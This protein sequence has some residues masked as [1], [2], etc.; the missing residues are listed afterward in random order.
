MGCLFCDIAS[1]TIPAEIIYED[2]ASIVFKD[3]SPKAPTHVLVIPKSHLA[4]L[5]ATSEEHIQ[6]LGHLQRVCA[7]VAELLELNKSGYRVVTNIGND[8]GQTVE[9]LHYHLLGGRQLNWPPG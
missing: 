3:I 5:S 6:L 4:S 7:H 2:D 8:G 9:H 1:K